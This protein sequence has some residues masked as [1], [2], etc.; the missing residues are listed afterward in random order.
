VLSS[1]KLVEMGV[2]EGFTP[3]LPVKEDQ[4]YTLIE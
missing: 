3:F 4:L 2:E 1:F